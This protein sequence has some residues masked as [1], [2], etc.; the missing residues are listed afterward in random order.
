[1]RAATSPTASTRWE[2]QTEII[3][4]AI[5]QRHYLSGLKLAFPEL[6]RNSW[7]AALGGRDEPEKAFFAALHRQSG[8]NFRA[9]VELWLSSIESAEDGVIQLK[10]PAAPDHRV[11]RQELGQV[12]QFALLAIEQHGSLTL[13]ELAAVLCEP[14]HMLRTRV[15]RLT[16]MGILEE[17]SLQSETRIC[18]RAQHTIEELLSSLN[19]T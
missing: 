13:S 18:A 9:A 6:R 8:G 17:E 4:R 15:D 19:L 11:F 10:E 3:E 1:M 14:K 12:D 7:Q 2:S 16:R 5:L